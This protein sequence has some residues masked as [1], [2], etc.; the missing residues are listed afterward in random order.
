MGHACISFLAFI[1]VY[2][3]KG[4]VE[5][6]C[7]LLMDTLGVAHKCECE[8]HTSMTLKGPTKRRSLMLGVRARVSLDP[9]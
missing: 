9:C 1:Y 5:T 7:F 6:M 3:P 4:D 8:T 2:S